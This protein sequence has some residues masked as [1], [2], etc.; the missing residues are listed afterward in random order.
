VFSLITGLVCDYMICVYRL[1]DF[2]VQL[3]FLESDELFSTTF[4]PIALKNP[5]KIKPERPAI[6][7]L[8]DLLLKNDVKYVLIKT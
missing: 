8:K 7:V 2:E 1:I 4:A 3:E 5:T 6:K